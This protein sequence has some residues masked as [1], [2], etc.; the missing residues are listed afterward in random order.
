MKAI[1]KPSTGHGFEEEDAVDREEVDQ[2]REQRQHDL[3]EDEVRQ[4]APADRAARRGRQNAA[5]CFQTDCIVPYAPAVALAPEPAERRR[6]LGPARARPPRR[7]RASPARPIASVRSVSSAS[8]VAR[9]AADLGER[10]APERADRARH[11]RHALQHLV[12]AAVE[13]EAHHV[14]DVL[15]A[16]EQPSA[17]ADLRVAGDRADVRLGGSGCTSS[18]ERVG[19]EDGVARRP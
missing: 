12:H 10:L 2:R 15:P 18:R 6:R 7:R 8:V 11:R 14:L 1:Q 17:V 9:D 4:A 16:A 3:E 5:R 19:L 13:V